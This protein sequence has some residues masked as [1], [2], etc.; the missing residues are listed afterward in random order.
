MFRR[1]V[2]VL[3]ALLAAGC[4][5]ACGGGGGGG[6]GNGSTSPPQNNPPPGG[7]S[8]GGSSPAPPQNSPPPAA[9][10]GNARAQALSATWTQRANVLGHPAGPSGRSWMKLTYD[11]VRKRTVLFAGSGSTYYND[12][13]LY[14]SVADK[15]QITEPFIDCP[16]M[17]RHFPPT[18]R[19]E[20]VVDYDSFNDLYWAFG[21][22]GFN[23]KGPARTAGAG[24]DTLHVVDGSLSSNVP[25]F[26]KHWTVEA[27]G[28]LKA[29]VSAYDAATRTLSLATPIAGLAPGTTYTLAPQRGGGTWNYNPATKTWKGFDSPFWGFTG[30]LPVS[31]L[32][33]AFAYSSKDRVIVMFGGTAN[34][35]YVNDTW[36]L[37]VQ[38]QSWAQ[39][40]ANDD[41]AA[42][43]KRAQLE[44]SMV[45]DSVNDVFILFGG[46]CKEPTKCQES[47]PLGDTWAYKVAT[48]TWTDMNPASRPPAREQHQMAFDPVNHAVVLFGG[49]DGPTQLNDLWAYDFQSNVWNQLTPSVSPPARRLASLAYDSA[50][51][52]FVL[53]GGA[54]STMSLGDMWTLKLAPK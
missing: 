3:A 52:V 21:G 50:E 6:Q 33:P 28:T 5:G 24:S 22:S 13:W 45:Y 54:N 19:D 31:R 47:S 7:A 44:N 16:S 12:I 34:G 39:L 37:D 29:Y 15:W 38:T 35:A 11:P 40:R 36:A 46:R 26:Y 43:F 9:G 41:A 18:K 20:L 1:S 27:G 30:Q 23:C 10:S 32:S 14:D 8:G 49:H 2:S 51:N 25:D 42:P 48:N 17:D 53:Y 4:L